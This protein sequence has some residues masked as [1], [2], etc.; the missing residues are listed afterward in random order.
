MAHK[1]ENDKNSQACAISAT[2]GTFV[3]NLNEN[4]FNLPGFVVGSNDTIILSTAQILNLI[5]VVDHMKF[6]N[7]LSLINETSPELDIFVS[8][9]NQVS[10]IRTLQLHGYLLDAQDRRIEGIIHDVTT[11]FSYQRILTELHHLTSQ[12][13]LDFE[14]KI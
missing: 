5:S 8:L 11:S 14:F 7:A 4:W 1:T 2:L 13:N 3:A 6:K 12:S 10:N 9:N